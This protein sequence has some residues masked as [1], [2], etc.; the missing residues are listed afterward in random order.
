[1]RLDGEATGDAETLL[2]ATGQT[3]ARLSSRSLTSSHK[4]DCRSDLS[5]ISSRDERER[6]RRGPNRRPDATFWAI[7]IVGKG[8]GRW[9]TIPT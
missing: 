5:T 6:C 4:P 7:D 2:L 9:N 1:M 8:F 3:A